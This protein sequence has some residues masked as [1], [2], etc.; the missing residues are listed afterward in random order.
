MTAD[1][2]AEFRIRLIDPVTGDVVFDE[3]SI[4]Q[5]SRSDARVTLDPGTRDGS[6]PIYRVRNEGVTD[7][8][9]ELKAWLE[10]PGLNPVSILN[11]D[12]NSSWFVQPG[13]ELEI[14]TPQVLRAAESIP[15]GSY[16]LKTRLIHPSTGRILAEH[17][18]PIWID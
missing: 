4:E 8:A 1:P 16:L 5:D 12:A 18:L 17:S 2:A 15:P 6:A 7:A 11:R 13:E 3:Q 10:A 14:E 9:V